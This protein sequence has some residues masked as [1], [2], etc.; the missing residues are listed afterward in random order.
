MLDRTTLIVA[1]NFAG[2]LTKVSVEG[3]KATA[4]PIAS[5]L[6]GPVSVAQS[7]NAWWVPEGQLQHYLFPD[8]GPPSLPFL[9]RRI[10]M[11]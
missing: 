4:T 5:N 11:P 8:S 9:V 3:M 10:P 1:E 2:R 7:G 6:R